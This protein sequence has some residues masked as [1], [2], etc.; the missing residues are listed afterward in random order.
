MRQLTLED[1]KKERSLLRLLWCICAGGVIVGS[2]LP[3]DSAV[4]KAVDYFL[5]NDRLQHFC[6]YGVLAFLPAIHERP[7]ILIGLLLLTAAMGVLLEFGQV[8]SPGRSFD[9]LDM[10]ADGL[11]IAAGGLMGLPLRASVSAALS[12]GT[13][14]PS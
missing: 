4:L 8:Y 7:R 12:R 10:A 9:V 11:G 5:S 6:A 1:R 13:K 14:R 3:G 2:L